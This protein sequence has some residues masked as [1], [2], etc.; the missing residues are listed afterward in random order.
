M[1]RHR[2]TRRTAIALTSAAAAS[3]VVPGEIAQ[4]AAAEGTQAAMAEVPRKGPFAIVV[5]ATTSHYG[6]SV[7]EVMSEDRSARVVRPRQVAM[8]LAFHLTGRHIPEIGRRMGGRDGVTV[9][10]ACRKMEG[11]RNS[12]PAMKRELDQFFVR[13]MRALRANGFDVD[14]PH[15]ARARR[16]LKDRSP[17][18]DPIRAITKYGREFALRGT[19]WLG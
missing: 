4:A 1:R 14:G 18:V 7:E 2:I 19:P 10:H 9:L 8:Y 5:E 6:V 11:L 16:F 13:C 12:D 15:Y 17:S 3:V